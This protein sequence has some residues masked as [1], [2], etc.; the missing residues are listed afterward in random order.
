MRF[1]IN[2]MKFFLFFVCF[3]EIVFGKALLR[4][5]CTEKGMMSSSLATHEMNV[6]GE[7]NEK[8]SR[9]EEKFYKKVDHNNILNAMVF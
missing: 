7:M 1:L 6:V 2:L 3:L 8:K 9:N 4:T 5:E